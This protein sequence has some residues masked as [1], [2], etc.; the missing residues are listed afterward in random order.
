MHDL[1]D[2]QREIRD[3]ARRFADEVVAPQAPAWDRDHTFP[4]DVVA[5]MGELGLLGAC[6]PAE[7]GGAGSK[8][9][10]QRA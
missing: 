5:Q 6:I 2:E 7:H 1:T 10:R 8:V 4:H 3:L 9:V